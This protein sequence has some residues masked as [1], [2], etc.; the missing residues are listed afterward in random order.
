MKLTSVVA[1]TMATTSVAALDFDIALDLDPRAVH[2]V[3]QS[4]ASQLWQEFL[5]RHLD[6][7]ELFGASKRALSDTIEGLL[8]N[9]VDSGTIWSLLD[10]LAENPDT[11]SN[12]GT[13]LGNAIDAGSS[14]ISE[15]TINALIPSIMPVLSQVADSGVIGSTVDS[16]FYNETNRDILADSLGNLL[17]SPNSTWFTTLLKDIGEGTP[18]S[19]DVIN[20]LINNVESKDPSTADHIVRESVFGSSSKQKRAE[21]SGNYTGSLNEFLG[22]VVGSISNSNIL[23][24]VVGDVAKAL[25]DS[26]VLPSI[27]LRFVN[28]TEYTEMTKTLISSINATGALSHVDLNKYFVKLKKS[29]VLSDGTQWLLSDPSFSPQMG[30]WFKRMEDTGVYTD[31]QRNLYGPSEK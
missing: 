2:E 3:E 23:S 27:I 26:G 24:N 21:S 31:V 10:S 16:L 1:L 15:D 8:T 11:V 12:L 18:L 30:L 28:T 29:N 13:V 7:E 5:A 9:V 4:E 6:D 20:S 17:R 19:M 22:N 14:F 25:N